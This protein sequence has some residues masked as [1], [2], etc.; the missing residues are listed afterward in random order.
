MTR[1]ELLQSSLSKRKLDGLLIENPID[2]FYLTDLHLSRGRLLVTAAD[3]RLYVDGR[4]FAY[5]SARVPWAVEFW[6]ESPLPIPSGKVGFDSSS[7]SVEAWEKLRK[8]SPETNWVGLPKLLKEM[9][10]VK[11]PQEIA[12]L[13]RAAEVTWSGIEAMRSCLRI[14][15]SEREV[16]WEFEKC[17]RTRGASGL[18]FEPIVA[19]GK[20][21]ALPHHRAS[22]DRLEANQVVLIDAGA[23]VD[24]Y[25]GDV[26]RVVFFGQVSE[27][28]RNMYAWVKEAYWAAREKVRPGVLVESIDEAARGV[29]RRESVEEL[30]VHS[31]GHGIGLETH[32]PPLLKNK[33]PDA[34][35]QLET[36]MV[37]TIEPGLYV[38][39]IGGIRLEDTGIVLEEGFDS[40]YPEICNYFL[41]LQ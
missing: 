33:A 16:A 26:T 34:T 35:L 22:S 8:E 38:P 36:S 40:F 3:I 10:M 11:E 29:F 20:N 41:S 31:L 6:G 5:A 24:Q 1:I 21:S 27:R 14:G 2:L 23:I 18:S 15:I 28:L 37:F 7:T 39:E 13:R 25:C 19:F 30:F 9:R 12:A 4:Y 32:E 17:V